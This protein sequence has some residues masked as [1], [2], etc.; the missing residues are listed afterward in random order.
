M[1]YFIIVVFFNRYLVNECE[2]N[3]GSDFLKLLLSL[4]KR[5]VGGW[6][7]LEILIFVINC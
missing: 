1:W 5:I 3:K 2:I 7:M 4:S 6:V